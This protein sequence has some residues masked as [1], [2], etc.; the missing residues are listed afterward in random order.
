M[1]DKQNSGLQNL[2]FVDLYKPMLRSRLDMWIYIYYLTEMVF[3]IFLLLNLHFTHDIQE[4]DLENY[5]KTNLRRFDS[6]HKRGEPHIFF[7]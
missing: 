1:T 5:V 3:D 2:R 6:T 7:F 4:E